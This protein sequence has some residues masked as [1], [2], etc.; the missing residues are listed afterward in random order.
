MIF[1][2]ESLIC[3]FCKKYFDQPKFLP[4]GENSCSKCIPESGNFDCILCSESHSVPQNG[5]P[6]NKTLSKALEKVIKS[7]KL[8]F[9]I[10]DFNLNMVE[11][12]T[13]LEKLKLKIGQLDAKVIEQCK[14][15]INEIDLAAEN[16][17]NQINNIR[18]DLIKQVN[19]YQGKC[20]NN[21]TNFNKNLDE[22]S[23]EVNLLTK[24]K[25]LL[26]E[27][28]DIDEKFDKYYNVVSNVE[29]SLKII[30]Y[31]SL[32]NSKIHYEPSRLD[33]SKDFLGI[34][35]F[36]NLKKKNLDKL[37]L[38]PYSSTLPIEP[39]FTVM[40]IENVSTKLN[41]LEN[42]NLIFSSIQVI[43]SQRNGY[44]YN[45]DYYSNRRNKQ[46]QQQQIEKF[47]IKNL[48]LNK[49]LEIAI[50][51]QLPD[52]DVCSFRNFVFLMSIKSKYIKKYDP[53][54]TLLKTVNLSEPASLML[55]TNK[56]VLVYFKSALSG[57]LMNI[58][59]LDLNFVITIKNNEYNSFLHIPSSIKKMFTND[60]YYFFQEDDN[61]ITIVS[62]EDGT[63]FKKI[64]HDAKSDLNNIVK[65]TN[66]H[67]IVRQY[68][69]RLI[70]NSFNGK[71]TNPIDY[72]A[73]S[74]TFLIGD[75]NDIFLM[76]NST[77]QFYSDNF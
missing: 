15:I 29:L 38:L 58:Y 61:S 10:Q 44:K 32:D 31:L 27:K 22:L 77:Y 5:F 37:K 42:G 64:K 2:M 74:L 33:L 47:V 16:K 70:F 18:E 13:K 43:Q 36:E 50:E 7:E 63:F 75:Q 53:N 12:E 39:E 3:P 69:N 59:D 57:P 28:K 67:I 34:I 72:N 26:L 1:D 4:C 19:E 41:K 66:N 68:W 65:I 62:Q 9:K 51:N 23:E 35:S 24:D 49:I 40:S 76:D 55:S 25:D 71:L 48:S 14:S 6:T 20:L 30:Y 73:S 60:K 54:L 52:F 45:E 56:F 11:L 21:L 46:P 17:I 8:E